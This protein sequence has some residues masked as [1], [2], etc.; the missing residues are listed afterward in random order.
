MVSLSVLLF[1][2]TSLWCSPLSALLFDLECNDIRLALIQRDFSG[3]DTFNSSLGMRDSGG[4]R[5]ASRAGSELGA[6]EP[7]MLMPVS[8]KDVRPPQVMT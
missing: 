6:G 3:N 4:R 1:V 5:P 7:M 2:V 8:A